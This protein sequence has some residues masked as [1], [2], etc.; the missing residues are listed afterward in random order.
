[1]PAVRRP[2]VLAIILAGGRG[3]RLSPLTRDRSKPAVPFGGRY[4]IIDFVLSNF[5]NSE[6]YSIFV[7]VQYKSQSLID[8]LTGAWR[9]G[10]LLRRQFITVVPPQM[11]GG[12]IWYQ[13]TADAVYQNLNLI[14]DYAPDL[15]AVF[16]ADHIYRMDIGQMIQFHLEKRAEATVAALPVPIEAARG[17]GIIEVDE[18]DRITG[19][20]EK[21]PRPTPMPSDPTRA[22]ASM[23]NY[24]FNPKPL[25]AMLVEDAGRDTEHDFGKTIIGEMATRYPVFA[26]NFLRNEVPGVQAY[27]EPGYWRDVGNLSAYWSAHMDLLGATP[28]FDLNNW[29]WPIRSEAI[30]GLPAKVVSGQIEDS[31]IGA[32]SV[33]VGARVRRSIIG[34]TVRIHEGAE[35]QESIIMDHTTI[36]KGAKLRRAIVDRFNAIEA[37]DTM[38]YDRE[39]DKHR[40]YHVDPTGLVVCARGVTRWS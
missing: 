5:V 4:R 12:E 38:G 14:E 6:I 3:Q 8:H 34:H 37:G 13:G 31:I 22:Y 2:N 17:F 16:G 20:Q 23:G 29:H 10:G 39:R 32:G 21:P 40:G 26:Y 18:D 9:F 24:I 28:A 33:I 36:G 25:I 11:R 30:N 1:M 35:V 7:L 19:F 15:V 27:E